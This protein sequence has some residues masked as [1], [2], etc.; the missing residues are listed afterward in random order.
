MADALDSK[1]ST[2]KVCGFKSL[3]GQLI[4]YVKDDDYTAPRKLGALESGV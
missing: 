2:Q 4:E 3:L 1:S